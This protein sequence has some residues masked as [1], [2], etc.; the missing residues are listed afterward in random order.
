MDSVARSTAINL[1]ARIGSV[2]AVLALVAW[3]ARLGPAEQGAFA[4]FTSVE[5]TMLA[6]CSGLGVALARVPA[7]ADD[8]VALDARRGAALGCLLLGTAATPLLWALALHGGAAY[9]HL[10]LLAL[11]APLLLLTPNLSGWWLG[12]G[13]MRPLAW[14]TLLPP[15]LALLAVAGSALAGVR[16]LLAVLLAWVLAKVLVG[17]GLALALL[18]APAAAGPDAQSFQLSAW[19]AAW[20][21]AACWLRGQAG[22]VL[23]I[24]LTNLVSLL[25]YRVG[26]FVVERMLGLAATGVYSIAVVVAELLWFVSSALTQAVYGRLGATDR[27]AAAALTLRVLQ[28]SLLAL[29]LLATPLLAVAAWL[30]PALLGPAYAPVWGLLALLLPGVV[31]FGGASALSAYFTQHLGQPQVPAQVAALSLAINL[32]LSLLWVPAHGAAGAA[33]AASIAYATTMALLAWRFVRAAGWPLA[34][35]WRP[36]P[37][38]AADLALLWRSLASVARQ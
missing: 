23:T 4:L 36:G 19:L 21:R 27:T 33:A 35:L 2:L 11:A 6:L 24:G 14:A 22:F 16:G 3:T 29:V 8:G 26:L 34:A 15:A 30:L 18:A 37:H 28:L 7:R 32:G 20:R 13:R 9:Q 10:W 25:N 31:L 5:A 38:L 12:Q 1:F 17:G